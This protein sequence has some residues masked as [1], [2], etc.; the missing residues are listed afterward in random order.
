MNIVLIGMPG[1]GKS[2]VGALAAR[3]LG[4]TFVE[5]DSLIEQREGTAIPQI[6][7]HR[8]ESYFRDVESAVASE[9]A[10]LENAVIS[11][12]GG[13][14]LRSQNMAALAATGI[15]FFL[16]REVDALAGENHSGRPLLAGDRNHILELYTNRIELYRKYAKHRI[17]AGKT[18]EESLE[19]LLRAVE[20]EGML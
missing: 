5:T 7:A 12:G 13:M 10:T 17:K 14:V 3:R 15:I 4:R 6:F 16:D 9:A 1:A 18:V 20:A 2:T 19:R 11:T 8:G